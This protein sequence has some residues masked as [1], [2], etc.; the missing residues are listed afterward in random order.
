MNRCS[1]LRLKNQ[2]ITRQVE[3]KDEQLE[4]F[5]KKV[6]SVNHELHKSEKAKREVS[7]R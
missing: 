7:C 5:R 2:K 1:E 4:E 6:D 3:E